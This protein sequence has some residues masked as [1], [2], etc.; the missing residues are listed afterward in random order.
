MA[1]V[2]L[3]LTDGRPM[4]MVLS[5][6]A[7]LL[8]LVPIYL[9]RRWVPHLWGAGGRASMQDPARLR[10]GA[11]RHDARRRGLQV[12]RTPLGELLIPEETCRWPSGAPRGACR[13]WPPSAWSAC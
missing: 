5:L 6:L 10:L 9:M 13:P 1:E 8:Y 3:A 2:A 12:V 11:A 7:P 4:Q